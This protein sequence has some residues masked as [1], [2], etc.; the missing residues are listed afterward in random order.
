MIIWIT[1]ASTGIGRAT[2]K[3]FA[4]RGDT[5][6]VSARGADAL[7][8]LAEECSG[9]K[10]QIIPKPCDTTD[11]EAVNQAVAEAEDE[12]GP[13]DLA[14]LNAGVYL[15]VRHAPFDRDAYRKTIDIN[16]QGT[17][18]CL[19]PLI[20]R[21]VPRKSGRIYMVSSVAGY[22]GLPTSAAYGA[23]K[24]AMINLAESLKFDL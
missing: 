19:A 20:D 3:K 17:V 24:A 11:E 14:I 13:I 1:G 12:A 10:G 16:L 6:I 5:A 9:L 21:M 4:A 7:N 18:N 22:S 8:S 2:A 23:S 15:P